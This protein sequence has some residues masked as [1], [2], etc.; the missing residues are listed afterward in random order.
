[1][2]LRVSKNLSW[3][4]ERCINTGCLEGKEHQVVFPYQAL[5]SG[6]EL[7]A[8]RAVHAVQTISL[9]DDT[10]RVREMAHEP[11]EHTEKLF[12]GKEICI[13][14]ASGGI[15]W[16]GEGTSTSSRSKVINVRD[17]EARWK[18]EVL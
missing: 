3:R 18:Q 16:N 17:S 5:E 7:N 15:R 9:D 8:S 14:V 12:S 1:M 2:F 6:P 10:T 11:S 4:V 13:D